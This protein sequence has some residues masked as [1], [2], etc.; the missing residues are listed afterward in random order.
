V[1]VTDYI[2][3]SD[4]PFVG[5]RIE[6]T[7][8]RDVEGLGMGINRRDVLLQFALAA[9]GSIAARL[10]RAGALND[11]DLRGPV[12]RSALSASQRDMVAV[13][14]ELI[15]PDTDTPGAGKAGVPTFIE[16]IVTSWYLPAERAIFVAGLA[17]LDADC[18]K[19]FGLGFADCSDEQ[20]SDALSASEAASIAFRNAEKNPAMGIQGEP[21][22]D[23]P[24]F[25][26]LKELTVLGYYTSEVG[27][28]T[29]LNY[30]P[31]PGRFDG[32]VD[33][34]AVGGRQWSS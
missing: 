5:E 27:S 3:S 30:N 16:H 23:S 10:V 33:F 31:I 8:G 14:A 12:A 21:D 32:D 25:H 17:E 1:H 34:E 29:E 20:R 2:P 22:A 13:L 6:A 26:K 28:T 15:I 9:S 11:G 4:N 24:F 7:G 18:V 19:R